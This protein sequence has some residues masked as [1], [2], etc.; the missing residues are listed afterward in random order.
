VIDVRRSGFTLIEL[1]VVIAIIAILAGILFPV[2]AKAR[3]KGRGISC[4][5]NLKQ[6]GSASLMYAQDYDDWYVPHCIRNLADFNEHPS[7]YWFE[8]LYPYT[9]S[10]QVL[11]CPSHGGAVGGNG[12]V[13]SYGYLCDGFTL[14]PTNV[15]FSGTPFGGYGSLAQIYY[16]SEMIMLGESQSATCRVCPL[17]HNHAM[18]AAPPVWPVQQRHNGGSNYLFFDGHAKWLKYDQTVSSRNMWKNLP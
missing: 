9:G 13:G 15:N 4:L 11:V 12:I 7:Y 17:Y 5:S 1:L 2:F 10:Y 14:D 3:E 8:L 16:P 6:L 18:P